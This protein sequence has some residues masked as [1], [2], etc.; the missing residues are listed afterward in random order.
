MLSLE[1]TVSISNGV[2][3]WK[4][5]NDWELSHKHYLLCFLG[6]LIQGIMSFALLK[7]LNKTS[8]EQLLTGNFLL[9]KTI[10]SQHEFLQVSEQK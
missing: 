9:A 3:E 8:R 7:Y 5:F 10:S 1:D 2:I 4:P 6:N